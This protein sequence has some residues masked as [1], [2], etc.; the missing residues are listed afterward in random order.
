MGCGRSIVAVAPVFLIPF[1]A[2]SQSV[3]QESQTESLSHPVES[4]IEEAISFL[5]AKGVLANDPVEQAL[6]F[7][8]LRDPASAPKGLVAVYKKRLRIALKL[9]KLVEGG[10]HGTYHRELAVSILI[11]SLHALQLKLRLHQTNV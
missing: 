2:P 1:G 3:P 9:A 11:H 5:S 4:D 10:E 8:Y 7:G 6:K